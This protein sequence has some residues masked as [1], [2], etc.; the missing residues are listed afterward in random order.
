MFA[1]PHED[2]ARRLARRRALRG[3]YES[4]STENQPAARARR[5]L[6]EWL[7]PD[8]KLQLEQSGYFEVTGGK[9]GTRYRI[10]EGHCANVLELDDKGEPTRGWC[11][12]PAGGLETGD[13]MLAQKIALES[14]EGHARAVANW[15]PPKAPVM[16]RS[17]TRTRPS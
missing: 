4:Y 3:L 11:F 15:F 6:R 9:T 2:R 12:V 10:L 8:Q 7:S 16:A 5:L 1:A 13:V 14:C 17:L